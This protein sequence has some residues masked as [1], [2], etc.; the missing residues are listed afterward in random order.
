M[1]T[2]IFEFPHCGTISTSTNQS[3]TSQRTVLWHHLTHGDR[4][5]TISPRFLSQ[6]KTCTFFVKVVLMTLGRRLDHALAAVTF[7]GDAGEGVCFL[8]L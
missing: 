3:V 1:E 7:G 8:L 4:S 6:K 5:P 2:I